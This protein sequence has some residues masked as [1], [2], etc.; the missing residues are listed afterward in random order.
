MRPSRPRPKTRLGQLGLHPLPPD[1]RVR[2]QASPHQDQATASH[3]GGD[4]RRSSNLSRR[5][6][7]HSPSSSTSA[8]ERPGTAGHPQVVVVTPDAPSHQLLRANDRQP[9]GAQCDCPGAAGDSLETGR[10]APQPNPAC[11]STTGGGGDRPQPPY[12]KIALEQAQQGSVMLRMTVNDAGLISAIEVVAILRLSHPGP[13]RHGICE[14][15]LD[16]P[17]RQRNSD[18]RSH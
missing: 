2:I 10:P 1:W 13:Q 17:A 7:R 8:A 18:L 12:P 14:T 6:L 16:G 9:G 5:H 11:S 4:R 15:A 3:R